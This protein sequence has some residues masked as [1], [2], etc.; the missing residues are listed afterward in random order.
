MPVTN[1]QTVEDRSFD[2]RKAKALLPDRAPPMSNVLTD[3]HLRS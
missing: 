3:A 1:V 2:Q